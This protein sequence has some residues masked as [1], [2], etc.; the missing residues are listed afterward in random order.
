MGIIRSNLRSYHYYLHVPLCEYHDSRSHKLSAYNWHIIAFKVYRRIVE[1]YANHAYKDQTT[2]IGVGTYYK[3][4]IKP[5]EG[6]YRSPVLIL[7]GVALTYVIVSRASRSAAFIIP[8]LALS[9]VYS[10]SMLA[11]LNN[12]LRIPGGRNEIASELVIDSSD[13]EGAAAGISTR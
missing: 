3:C 13:H 7:A 5:P 6:C 2:Y 9:K 12:R 8:G 11:L 4:V 10:N 1:T